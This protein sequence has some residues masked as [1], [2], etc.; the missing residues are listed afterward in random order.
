MELGAMSMALFSY[1]QKKQEKSMSLMEITKVIFKGNQELINC[2][3]TYLQCRRK[4][5]AM[6]SSKSWTIQLNLLKNLPDSRQIYQVKK[7]T[8]RGWRAVAFEETS[9]TVSRNKF[10]GVVVNE[11]F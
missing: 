7:A 2:L 9:P 3:A 11:A 1:E 10:S 6:P 8:E 5:R 4:E